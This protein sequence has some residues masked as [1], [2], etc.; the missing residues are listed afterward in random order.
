MRLSKRIDTI[1]PYIFNE[2]DIL[3]SQVKDPV[4]F[5]IGD[6][7]MPTP[8]FI[9]DE[10][11]RTAGKAENHRYP[12]YTG[13][14]VLREE[15]ARYF[16]KR[17][18]VE[19][20][21]DNEII[22]LI[23]S[24]EGIAHSMQS[25]IDKG[26]EMLI[27]SICYPVYRVQAGLWGA[28]TKEFPV[29][30]ENK[31]VPD[32]ADMKKKLTS[33]TKTVFINYPNNP[34]SAVVPFTFYKDLTEL[35]SKHGFSI[36]NDAVYSE[37]YFS[38]QKPH[39]ILEADRD[40]QYSLEFHSFSKTF[41]MTGWRIGFAVGNRKLIEG[42]KKIK[43]N[44]DS[45]VF[46]PIQY[47]AIKAL[48]RG[49]KHIRENNKLIKN[50]I[51]ILCDVLEEK[52]FEFHRPESTFYVFAKTMNGEDSMSFTKRLMKDAGIITTPGIG[53]GNAGNGFI[54]FSL[55]LPDRELAKG[56]RKIRNL[57]F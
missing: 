51:D 39:S 30:F 52:G 34:T 21:P 3:K 18:S 38:G 23:G 12:S 24:K 13:L 8:Q 20:D 15:I 17:F 50:R 26:D 4:D 56:I 36:I 47:A 27:P 41:N 19:L 49:S 31:F 54:R 28:K 2:L 10:L 44:T 33:R 40:K 32:L 16:S 25:L 43:M 45:G 7:D 53:F 9:T 57:K 5:G 14:R 46:N 55:T 29:R 1:P 35:A 42:L 37:V 48:K 22:V 6:P 11:T